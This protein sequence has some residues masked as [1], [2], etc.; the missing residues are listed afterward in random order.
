ME[1]SLLERREIE[2]QIAKPIFD[3]FAQELGKERALD[4]IG[5][6]IRRIARKQGKLLAQAYGNNGLT[7]FAETL[8]TWKKGGALEIAMIEQT[9]SRLSFNVTR[10]RYAEL[11]EDLEMKELGAVLSCG[12]D[13]AL[14]EGF[15]PHIA[16]TRTQTIMDGAAFCDFRF[17]ARHNSLHSH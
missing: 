8:E 7:A 11:Y 14:V 4:L 17:V 13:F 5:Q 16:L 10:C 9:E 6:V 1:M 12:R 3:T 15:N 2:A